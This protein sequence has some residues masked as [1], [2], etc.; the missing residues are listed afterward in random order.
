MK[1]YISSSWKNRLEVKEIAE[2]LESIGFD[3][4]DFTNP[5]CRKTVE[6]PP[7]NYPE[8]FDPEKHTYSTYI[9]TPYFVV[10]V[11]ESKDVIRMSDIVVLL[12]P[13]GN[14]AHIDWAFG[15]G[16]G[17]ISYIIGHPNK[18]ERTPTHNWATDI[19][20]TKEDFYERM[21]IF[22]YGSKA[23]REL[24]ESPIP[25][26]AWKGYGCPICES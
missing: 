2:K 5:K 10:A 7:E 18:G 11:N 26:K 21:K 23:F 13:C 4:Y 22:S 16:L 24:I 19:F 15:L 9:K 6:V 25:K 20:D 17:K 12:L 14:D 3:V 1:V 8:E